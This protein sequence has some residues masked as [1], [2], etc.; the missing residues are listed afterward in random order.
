MWI[1]FLCAGQS[2]PLGDARGRSYT[3]TLV[4]AATKIVL[5]AWIVALGLSTA[6]GE[7]P[8]KVALVGGRI[9]PV[10]GSEI[11]QGTVLIEHGVIT[12]VGAH[13]EIPYDAMEVDVTG[14]TLFPG[15]IDPHS[16]RGLDVANENLPV[17]PFLDVYDALDPS[18]LYFEDALR[19][20]ITSVHV[21]VANNCVIGGLSRV[22]RP[23]GLTPEE[24]T[25]HA[26]VALKLSV[27]PKR[28]S[29]RM[30]Q[31]AVLRETFLELG[32]YLDDLA[33]QKY[34][35]SLEEKDEKIDV[36]PDEAQERGRA[37]IRDED[38]DDEHANLVKLTRGDLGA[39]IYCERAADVAHA[40]TLARDNGFFDQTVLVLGP[41]CFKAVEEVKAAGRPVVLMPQLLHRERDPVTGD[42]RE[43]FVPA[44]YAKAGVAFAL[45]PHPNGSLAE[46]YLTYQAAR[47]VRHGVDRSQAL[48]A[49]T[50]NPAKALGIGDRVGS[51]EPGKVGDVVVLSG[52]PLDFN[53][54]VDLVYINGV[55]AYDREK[56][57]RLKRLLG[58]EAPEVSEGTD[59]SEGTEVSEGT[60]A[61]EATEAGEDTE[62][63]E[64]SDE[65]PK[66]A[67]Q[68]PK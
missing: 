22:V 8:A 16:S 3:E 9:I 14:K 49:I 34:E 36:G 66:P 13:V 50:I 67:E 6:S 62:P 7:P 42:V 20:G 11:P 30:V 33:E 4:N 15:M 44:V 31:M 46:R 58:D 32:D 35:E 39:F 57:V 43:T 45:T 65:V 24:M 37:L 29:G 41:E 47:C 56:D 48:E 61:S 59:A 28:G 64:A 23:I 25:L 51:L 60:D 19:D 68:E 1:G 63:S 40:V 52:D 21:I 12:A 18:R 54:W 5:S 26:P 10:V 55:L 27:A 17:T 2:Q 53:S 38:Y